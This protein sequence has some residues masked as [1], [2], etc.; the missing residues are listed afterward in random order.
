MTQPATADVFDKSGIDFFW[1]AAPFS[2]I[3]DK[4]PSHRVCKFG[5]NACLLKNFEG[6][7]IRSP[8]FT[9]GRRG[10]D[11]ECRSKSLLRSPA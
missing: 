5:I 3:Q 8:V 6:I 4:F 1:G 11:L 7:L 2:P 9:K 10:A